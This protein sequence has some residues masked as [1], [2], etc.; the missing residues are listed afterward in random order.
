MAKNFVLEIGTEEIPARFMGSAIAQMEELAG[1][2]LRENR[3]TVEK[4]A[5]YG[6]PRRLV[7]YFDGLVQ[8][9]EE[10]TEE[11]KGPARKAAFGADGN[12]TKAAEGFARS[13]GVNVNDLAIKET[14]NGEYVFASKKQTGRETMEILPEFCLGL[15]NGL[16]FPKP[17][18]WGNKEM[19]FARPIRWILSLFGNEVVS[20]EVEGLPSG[21]LTF[22]HRF[23]STGPIELADASEYFSKL[24]E[25]YVI[26]NHIER[27][28]II[29]NQV[30][31]LTVKEGGEVIP[32][33][34]LLEE[35]TQLLEY[36]TALCGTF[37]AEYLRLPKEVLVTPMREHQRYFPVI[38]PEGKLLAKF[39]T[40]RNGTAE[41]LDN[42]RAGN[43]KVLKARLA[44]AEFF[45]EEDLKVPLRDNIE[46]LKKIVFH[47]KLGTVYEKIK[48]IESIAKFLAKTT[49]ING[50][51]IMEDI[52]PAA[53]LCK[54][55][56]VTNMV[57][58]FPELQGIMG[59]EYALRNNEKQSVAEAVFEHYLPRFSGDVL[60]ATDLGRL[61][62]IADKIDT[63]IGCFA[64]GIQPTGSQDPYALRRQA[65]GIC[66]IALEAKLN[67]SV[68]RLVEEVYRIYACN[69][70]AKLSMEETSEE[71]G[72]F[73][74]QRLKNIFTEKGFSYDII[75]AVLASGYDRITDALLRAEALSNLRSQEIFGKLLTVYTRVANLAKNAVQED[76]DPGLFTE[77][78][79][80]VLFIEYVKTKD[81]MQI[82]LEERQYRQF[83]Q[84]FALL[85]QYIDSF[86]EGVMVM[87]DDETIKFNRLALLK[88]IAELTRPIAEL[89]KIVD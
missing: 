37:S 52:T 71:V 10:F 31:E 26:V 7:I 4:M 48:R 59:K 45:Y 12:P 67:F 61:I 16:S 28:E 2:W 15:I 66:Y 82:Y 76:I 17:M 29:K 60:P 55:D 77:E 42:V 89:T 14:P 56:L 1:N 20:F 68:S 47:E 75:E 64:V 50:G 41:F 30:A 80:K 57:F 8:K 72:E 23:L 19:R 36:P 65:L 69:I 62:S 24:K 85:Q 73:F 38:G 79:E 9:Q 5:T 81:E 63:I 3:L 13:Q 27:K 18:R 25:Q 39:I 53:H 83:F 22:G 78:A 70:K 44:D 33:E 21:K 74:K 84:R 87:V 35:V 51:Q 40:V 54:A 46:K 49:G 34:E 6:T 86:F 11:V 43:E 32:D 58:E 88:R